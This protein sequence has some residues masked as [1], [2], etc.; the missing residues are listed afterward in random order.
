[1]FST[2]F[3]PV[4]LKDLVIIEGIGID[5]RQEGISLD[6]Q[7]L[8]TNA[9]GTM[10]QDSNGNSTT[11]LVQNGKSI[12]D[13]LM[14]AQRILSKNM[15]Y[16]HNKLVA[17]SLEAV[18]KAAFS[19]ASYIIDSL[20]S[21][22]DIAVCITKCDALD[23]LNSS[24]NGARVPCENIVNLM[25]SN[26]KTGQSVF[27]TAIE[28]LNLYSDETSDLFLPV[29]DYSKQD[30][31][32]YCYGV[33][34]F[35]GSRLVRIFEA[36][37]VAGLLLLLGRLDSMSLELDTSQ[38]GKISAELTGIKTK[39]DTIISN[40]D[41]IF[42]SG[43]KLGVN[44]TA[45]ENKTLG[46]LSSQDRAYILNEVQR[47]VEKLSNN[48]FEELKACSSDCLRVGRLLSKSSPDS[49]VK[50][51]Q[52]WKFYFKRVKASITVIAE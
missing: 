25:K 39:N 31:V 21:R 28:A 51:K 22:S 9:V 17:V 20:N 23:I 48:A 14:L 43:I 10:A 15:Y 46:T 38:L 16:G 42:N 8:N 2:Y 33:G 29:L 1:M 27:V 19:D 3:T 35:S 40:G 6:L 45:V 47:E 7:Y 36:D 4:H 50:L 44:I 52:D 11:T 18:E 13:S 30:K 37:E 24:E 32:C 41:V 5:T 26:E 12:P 34:V 49:Y